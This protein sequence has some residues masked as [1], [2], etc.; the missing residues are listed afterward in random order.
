MSIS[1]AATRGL[2]DSSHL[3]F[4]SPH[5]YK[6]RRHTHLKRRSYLARCGLM[7]NH[8]AR[9]PLHMGQPKHDSGILLKKW[10]QSRWRR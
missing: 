10:R 3:R 6:A 9:V 7:G 8:S 1:N 2:G 5:N 4:A